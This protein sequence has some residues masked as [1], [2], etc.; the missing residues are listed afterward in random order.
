MSSRLH[1]NRGRQPGVSVAS[2]AI[3]RTII[4]AALFT[5]IAAC[6]PDSLTVPNY[7]SPT[8]GSVAGDPGALQFAV[9]GL[10]V[11]ARDNIG[12]WISGVGRLGRESYTYTQT[13]GRSTTCWL[14]KPAQDPSCGAGA[15][16]WNGYYAALRDIFNFKN[17]VQSSTTLSDA[18]KRAAMGFAETLEAYAIEFLVEARGHYGAPVEIMED[19]RELAPFVSRDSVY[20]YV[21]GTLDQAK[22]DLEAGGDSFPFTL[23]SGFDGFDTPVTFLQFNRALAARIDAERASLGVSGCGAA[24]APD[25]YQ[26][27]LQELDESFIDPANLDLGPVFVYSTAPGDEPNP[28]S[29]S[30]SSDF[31]AHPSIETDAEQQSNGKLDQ[32]Y[33]DKIYTLDIPLGPG[34]AVPGIF[35]DKD[36]IRFENPTDPIPVIRSEELVLLRA[37]ARW[38]TGDKPGAIA[39]INTVRTTS[40]HL[41]PSSLTTGSSDSDFLDALLY[42]RRYS[43][44]IEGRR[45]VDVR[46]FDMLQTLPV[47]VP[48]GQ[49]L[50]DD[51]VIPQT[52][53]L[54]R[55]GAPAELQAPTCGG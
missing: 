3:A 14:G 34:G 47:D 17:T 23:T 5:L 50:Y 49:M 54:S 31:V 20:N 25:C 9:N 7:N 51:L 10:L 40:G 55:V 24:L 12:G 19:P 33:L 43:L 1:G 13:E 2:C 32:R 18:Q 16:L 39:D 29:N 36:F 11:D 4:L 26:T 53:C 30:S 28:L 21:K 22:A 41:P 48:S 35:T 45:W 37:E 27:A 42:E 38:F 15:S 52:E 46:R 44:L 6:N 8:P